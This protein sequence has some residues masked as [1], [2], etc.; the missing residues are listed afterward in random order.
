MSPS[1]FAGN[2]FDGIID[3]LLGIYPFLITHPFI[4][5]IKNNIDEK[6]NFKYLTHSFLTHEYENTIFYIDQFEE[7]FTDNQF[8]DEERTRVVLLLR[9]LMSTQRLNIFVSMRNDFYNRLAS[10][11]GLTKSK[12]YCVIVDIPKV[13]VSEIMDIVNE[14]ARKAGLRWEVDNR[15]NALSKTIIREAASLRDLS[16]IE[17]ALSE[18]YNLRDENNLLTFDAYN[19]IGG[20]RGAIISYADKF[21]NSLNEKEQ[22]ILSE[23]GD[24]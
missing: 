10:Y 11:G 21:Y 1:M 8:T 2:M 20:L 12:K 22:T 16:L 7:L 23:F 5:E 17:F 4:E 15:G 6:T 18:L 19:K 14:P 9:G 3:I 13:G 24:M